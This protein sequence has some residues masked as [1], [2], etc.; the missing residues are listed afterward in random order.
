MAGSKRISA[1]DTPSPR[2]RSSS[3][4]LS[5]IKSSMEMPGIPYVLLM[6]SAR[7]VFPLSGGPIRMISGGGEPAGT[8]LAGVCASRTL[9]GIKRKVT[10]MMSFAT[11][12]FDK[13]E[14]WTR[15]VCHGQ[16]H[17]RS[18]DSHS[19][20]QSGSK[21]RLDGLMETGAIRHG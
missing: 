2:S 8:G 5:F 19:V 4:A 1:I 7:V 10:R 16:Y 13:P 12:D 20:S 14:F 11:M 6:E 21:S 15:L 17:S 9:P 18:K 3:A